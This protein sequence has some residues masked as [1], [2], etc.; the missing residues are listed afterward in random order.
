MP[1]LPGSDVA[2]P[3]PAPLSSLIGREHEVAAIA[4]LLRQPAVRLVTLTG[5][6]GVGKTRLANA[7]VD[8]VVRMGSPAHVLGGAPGHDGGMAAGTDGG[9]RTEIGKTAGKGDQDADVHRRRH[10]PGDAGC[11]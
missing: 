1:S 3:L 7:A 11:L 4:G 10:G 8:G 2:S 6:G 5:P 9:V